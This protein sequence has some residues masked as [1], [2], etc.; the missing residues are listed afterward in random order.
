[1]DPSPVRVRGDGVVLRE[2]TDADLPA[3]VELFD[4]PEIAAWT[5]IESPFDAAAAA[6]YLGRARVRRAEGRA[7]QLAVTTDGGAPRG[8]VLL[9]DPAGGT[10]ELGYAIGAAHRRRGLARAAVL[11]LVD[12]AATAFGLTTFVLRIPPANTASHAVARACGFAPAGVPLVTRAAKGRR[13][14]LE[15]WSLT[16]ARSDGSAA[17]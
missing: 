16:P 2:W 3:L 8:E 7:L 15:T 11:A 10:A 14:R 5:P 9:F 13:V 1:M 6:R 17:R 4:E 12:H